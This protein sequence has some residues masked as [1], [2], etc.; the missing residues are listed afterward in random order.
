MS[1]MNMWLIAMLC[2]LAVLCVILYAMYRDQRNQAKEKRE[3]EVAGRKRQQLLDRQ[4]NLG[5]QIYNALVEACSHNPSGKLRVERTK[6]A[7]K[8][9][10]PQYSIYVGWEEKSSFTLGGLN[11]RGY[12]VLKVGV[13]ID[14]VAVYVTVSGP[15]PSEKDTYTMSARRFEDGP[16]LQII[17]SRLTAYSPLGLPV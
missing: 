4:D 9:Q 5:N 10:Q 15:Y 7:R 17:A 2:G 1:Y 11:Y 8:E 6:S 14:D 3:R 13:S 16:E 12:P